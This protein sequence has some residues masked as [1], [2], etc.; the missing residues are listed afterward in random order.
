MSWKQVAAEGRGWARRWRRWC[1]WLDWE[2]R[3]CC[4]CGARC[5]RAPCARWYGSSPG[6]MLLRRARSGAEG[7]RWCAAAGTGCIGLRVR[8]DVAG[9]ADRRGRGAV[10]AG[11]YGTDL[12]RVGRRSS[13]GTG[14][15]PAEKEAC[16][17]P[18]EKR[19][20]SKEGGNIKRSMVKITKIGFPTFFINGDGGQRAGW[21]PPF[22]IQDV[23]HGFGCFPRYRAS[24][25]FARGWKTSVNMVYIK[26]F[27]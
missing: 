27:T 16:R 6:G 3:R 20:T 8:R 22:F 7:W 5:R 15:R 26:M 17:S 9:G 18:E 19:R 24:V 13:G 23:V 11:R 10:R 21:P 1:C 12:R 14:G 25:I 2:L 4:C